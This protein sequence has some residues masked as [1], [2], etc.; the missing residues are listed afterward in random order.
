MTHPFTPMARFVADE[1]KGRCYGM[2][3]SLGEQLEAWVSAAEGDAWPEVLVPGD[4]TITLA[5]PER[6]YRG[7][8]M[9]EVRV[10]LEVRFISDPA[11]FL[12]ALEYRFDLS[13]LATVPSTVLELESAGDALVGLAR[14]TRKLERALAAALKV[15]KF[16]RRL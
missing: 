12:Y 7:E 3:S 14:R 5:G 8:H 1:V 13:A 4:L 15:R 10:V 11:R 9:L 16:E 2:P 6:V